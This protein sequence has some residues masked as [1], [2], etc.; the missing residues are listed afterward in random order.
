L[1]ESIA[2]SGQQHIFRQATKQNA[3]C[4]HSTE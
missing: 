3:C 4:Q 2:H 1:I